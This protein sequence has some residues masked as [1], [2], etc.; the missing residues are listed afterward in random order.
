MVK[1]AEETARS[2]GLK[3]QFVEARSGNDLDVA[4]DQIGKEPA[5]ALVML[6]SPTFNAQTNLLANVAKKHRLPTMYEWRLFPTAGGLISYGAE[7]G[8]IYRRAAAFVDKILKGAKPAD[9]PVEQPT[10]WNWW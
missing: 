3:L 2:L 10:N 9:L 5:E 1:D 6:M 8:D 4:F 7:P